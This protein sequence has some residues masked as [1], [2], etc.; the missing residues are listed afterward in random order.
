M[1]SAML[2]EPGI[3]AFI[4]AQRVA[5]LTTVD[6]RGRPHVVPICFALSDGDV[7]YTAIDEK[8]KTGD[9]TRLRRIRNIIANPH[10]Q[11]LFD[12][13]D[14]GDWSKLRY[15]QLRGTA[16]ILGLDNEHAAA[17]GLLRDRYSQYLVMGLERRPVIAVDVT[18]AV[19]W[20]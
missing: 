16:R 11:V 4:E 6:D 12:R 10:V 15:V 5:R 17:V 18:R 14:D 3:R 7:V 8:P 2:I 19:A 13:Y 9:V 1:L 20:P